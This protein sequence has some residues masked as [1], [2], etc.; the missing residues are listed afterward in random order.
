MR[1]FL[2]ALAGMLI[3]SAIGGTVLSRELSSHIDEWLSGEGLPSWVSGP[4]EPTR[5][6]YQYVDEG[7]SVRFVDSL[8]EVPEA[9][10]A[11]AGHI[12]IVERVSTGHRRAM[13]TAAASVSGHAVVM[14]TAP[15]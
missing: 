9:Q 15:G 13:R 8:D 6:V 4:S 11:T 2:L 1:S 14:Y 3:V 12:E 7:G 10:R 5:L